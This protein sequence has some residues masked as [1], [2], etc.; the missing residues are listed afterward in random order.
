[1]DAAHEPVP[2]ISEEMVTIFEKICKKLRFL[3]TPQDFA[4]PSLKAF[5]SQME[6]L[7]FDENEA[8]FDDDTLPN[9]EAQDEKIAELI[10]QFNQLFEKV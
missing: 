6:A 3:F 4:N 5:Y 8:T 2:E 1:M 9:V 10:Q 7:V